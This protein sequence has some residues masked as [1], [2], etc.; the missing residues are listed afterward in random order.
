MDASVKYLLRH[1]DAALVEIAVGAILREDKSANIKREL[2]RVAV[3]LVVEQRDG[4][5]DMEVS[6]AAGRIPPF[7]MS[8]KDVAVVP[9]K[10]IAAQ[11][12]KTDPYFEDSVERKASTTKDHRDYL[13]SNN[14]RLF[15][16]PSRRDSIEET[17]AL[18]SSFYQQA[19]SLPRMCP[20][21]M[22]PCGR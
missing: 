2:E 10:D 3:V 7:Q 8:R 12:G 14:L 9:L 13:C 22:P 4:W 15:F 5:E 6:H 20:R 19:E 18:H 1:H 21:Y 17:S 16:A 11:Y